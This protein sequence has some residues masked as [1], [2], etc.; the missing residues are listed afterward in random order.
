[1][2]RIKI[3]LPGNF[4]Y[5]YRLSVRITDINYGGHTGNDTVLKYMHEARMNFLRSIGIKDEIRIAGDIGWIVADAAIEYKSESF[6]GENVVLLL[7]IDD[8][9]KYGFDIVYLLKNEDSGKDIAKGKTGIV[10]FDYSKR[11]IAHAPEEFV[12]KIKALPAI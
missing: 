11:K 2:A 4:L 10:F 3:E 1:M 5:K 9:H 8:L 12:K 7:G 6:F